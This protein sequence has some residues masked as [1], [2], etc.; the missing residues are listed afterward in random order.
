MALKDL[1]GGLSDL[2]SRNWIANYYQVTREQLTN[3]NVSSRAALIKFMRAFTRASFA[4]IYSSQ[5]PWLFYTAIN[6]AYIFRYFRSLPFKLISDCALKSNSGRWNDLGSMFKNLT[7]GE[8][9]LR[10]V[11]WLLQEKYIRCIWNVLLFIFLNFLETII[12]RFDRKILN[13][14]VR[15]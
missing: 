8:K 7:W 12:E 3:E 9:S 15:I 5:W 13:F 14:L 11:K 1:N 4:K 6:T 10:C 2:L